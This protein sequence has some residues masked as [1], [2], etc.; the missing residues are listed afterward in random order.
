MTKKRMAELTKRMNKDGTF[1]ELGHLFTIKWKPQ[2]PTLVPGLIFDAK[3]EMKNYW[4]Q[5]YEY[6]NIFE[7]AIYGI[8]SEGRFDLM[9][10]ELHRTLEDAKADAEKQWDSFRK[11]SRL[12]KL[13]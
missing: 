3:T 1:R 12:Y 4:L 5:V 7:S 2:D 9:G 10:R 11:N 8:T 13:E 6:R